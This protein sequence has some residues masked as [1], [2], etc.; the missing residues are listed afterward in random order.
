MSDILQRLHLGSNTIF[1]T[2][3]FT[4]VCIW[5]RRTLVVC[6]VGFPRVDL[7]YALVPSL[8]FSAVRLSALSARFTATSRSAM[9]AARVS[10]IPHCEPLLSCNRNTRCIDA[11]A[12][13]SAIVSR[14][15]M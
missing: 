3:T 14:L 10:T 11:P 5:L 15:L 9:F 13:L 2:A 6:I 4:L 7:T 12:P 8:I 1:W